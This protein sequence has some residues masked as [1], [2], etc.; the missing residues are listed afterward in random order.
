MQNPQKLNDI[1]GEHDSYSPNY[2][3][4]SLF[5]LRGLSRT[6]TPTNGKTTFIHKILTRSK[7]LID[8]EDR[9][10][11]IDIFD[12]MDKRKLKTHI[13]FNY[14]ELGYIDTRTVSCGNINEEGIL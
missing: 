5:I 1:L 8:S 7:T 6:P 4:I 2:A 10:T 3:C 11:L 12:I 13:M 9:L 14:G